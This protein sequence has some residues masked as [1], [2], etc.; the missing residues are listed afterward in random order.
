MD[1]YNPDFKLVKKKKKKVSYPDF[2]TEENVEYSP[3][4]EE[5]IE[6]KK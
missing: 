4:S 2:A 6:S 5:Y 3:L 1:R